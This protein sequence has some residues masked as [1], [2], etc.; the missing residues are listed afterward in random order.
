MAGPP[1]NPILSAYLAE[2]GRHPLIKADEEKRLAR[3]IRDGPPTKPPCDSALLAA[4]WDIEG[5]DLARGDLARANL[6]LVVS[7]ARK[8]GNNGR[9]PLIDRI[10]DGNIGLMKA[11]EK[12]D[13]ERGF[14]FSTYA[15]WWIKQSIDR[16]AALDKPIHIPIYRQ[17]QLNKVNKAITILAQELGRRPRVEEIAQ[18]L[19]IKES[20]VRDVLSIPIRALSM[21]APA[22]NNDDGTPLG[23]F[24]E[25]ES[26]VDAED[27]TL[28]DEQARTTYRVLEETLDA[29]TLAMYVE[30]FGLVD[31]EER[32]LERVGR[33]HDLTRE[34]VR[35]VIERAKPRLRAELRK[36]GVK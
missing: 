36:A 28:T 19:E 24:M 12:F 21:D 9:T 14:K 35:Q 2:V 20:V 25:D 13:P 32:S 17:E 31:D 11:V 34:R 30:R 29:R 16:N 22:N 18:F 23:H 15:S 8:R 26:A 7:I 27:K 3:I 1:N 5:R 33:I 6:R 10:Q 4:W